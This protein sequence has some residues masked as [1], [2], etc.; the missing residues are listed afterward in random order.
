MGVH[1]GTAA[2]KRI[3]IKVEELALLAVFFLLFLGS[4]EWGPWTLDQASARTLT[5]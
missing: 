5:G 3:S 2:T 4:A 1:G